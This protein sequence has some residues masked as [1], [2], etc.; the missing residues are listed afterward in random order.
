MPRP[1]RV[2][3]DPFIHFSLL[4]RS[5]N[6][7][8]SNVGMFEKRSLLILHRR[9]RSP[10]R[11]VKRNAVPCGGDPPIC[12]PTAGKDPRTYDF[13]WALPNEEVEHDSWFAE[14]LGEGRRD[15][16]CGEGRRP[17]CRQDPPLAGAPR[18]VY[19]GETGPKS[20]KPH[21]LRYSTPIDGKQRQNGPRLLAFHAGRTIIAVI[22]S[23]SLGGP[24]QGE[25]GMQKCHRRESTCVHRDWITEDSTR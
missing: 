22:V 18:F 11:L 12:H 9:T 13:A 10:S 19:C 16:S 15:T 21:R 4:T 3:L 6:L 5:A 7:P 1:P 14:S 17:L 20:F 24:A 8:R 23:M 2:P 25:G